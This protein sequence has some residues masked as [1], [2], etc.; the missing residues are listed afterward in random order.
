MLEGERPA[1]KRERGRREREREGDPT[2]C[3]ETRNDLRQRESNLDDGIL[4]AGKEVRDDSHRED[5]VVLVVKEGFDGPNEGLSLTVSRMTG[6]DNENR[7]EGISRFRVV[8]S[9]SSAVDG[10]D[11]EEGRRS[12][13]RVSYFVSGTEGGKKGKRGEGEGEKEEKERKSRKTHR[14]NRRLPHS[15]HSIYQPH[16]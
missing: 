3:Q 9:T 16:L 4:V 8:D 15:S 5:R 14:L 13:K 11:L 7:V 6:H 2:R 10:N 12:K 1:L